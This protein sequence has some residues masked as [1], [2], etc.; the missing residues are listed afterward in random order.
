MSFA[1]IGNSSTAKS[2]SVPKCQGSR[3]KS[4]PEAS[5]SPDK[6][7][8]D[9]DVSS[10]TNSATSMDEKRACPARRTSS[11]AMQP[12][13]TKSDPYEPTD[14][15]VDAKSGTRSPAPLEKVAV[16]GSGSWGTALA[17]VA[18]VNVAQQ[19]GFHPEVLMWVRDPDECAR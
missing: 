17:R 14:Y 19:D 1:A 8:A 16:I 6:S 5:P 2:A 7:G 13:I 4:D 9:D 10:Q 11:A 18:A 3:N 15:I 12:F